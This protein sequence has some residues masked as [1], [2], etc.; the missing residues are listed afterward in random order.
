M[1]KLLFLILLFNIAFA[2]T[3]SPLT[4]T[5]DNKKEKYIIFKVKNPTAQPVAVDIQV[6]KLLSTDNNKEER[7]VTDKISYYPSQFVLSPNEI[8]NVRL[9]Y[10]GA[11][12]PD[13]EEVFRVIAKELDIDV[14]DKNENETSTG[15]KS[16][17][18]MRYSYEGLLLIHNKTSKPQLKIERFQEL[19]NNELSL[20]IRNIGTSSVVPTID[21][22]N[23][24]VSINKKE[25]QLQPKDM[26]NAELRRALA[27]QTNTYILKHITTLPQTG[28]IDAI[29]LE[30]REQ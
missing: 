14:S 27:G 5:V 23:F 2:I 29:R 22:Y 16:K 10:T 19:A 8:K 6:L 3:L 25:Y 21:K 11:K 12:L 26:Q 7:V 4:K 30:K 20:S 13:I 28:K 18:K 15:I 24:I 1:K 9:R 17:L